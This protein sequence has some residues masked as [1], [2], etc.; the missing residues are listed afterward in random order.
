MTIMISNSGIST[1]SERTRTSVT[2]PR[3]IV[4]VS[5]EIPSRDSGKPT[6]TNQIR[7][8]PTK[9]EVTRMI[10]KTSGSKSISSCREN[11]LLGHETTVFVPDNLPYNLIVLHLLVSLVV[12]LLFV[13]NTS[14]FWELGF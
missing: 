4:W 3:H 7:E 8:V 14:R 11:D 9:I 12:L 13:V 2:N 1:V 6:E 10:Y 5:T